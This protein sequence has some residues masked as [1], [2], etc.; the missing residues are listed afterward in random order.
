MKKSIRIRLN[1]KNV[2]NPREMQDVK[3][4]RGSGMCCD[5]MEV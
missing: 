4:G 5:C 3:G 2:L 1:K